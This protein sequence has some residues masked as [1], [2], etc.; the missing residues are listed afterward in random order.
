MA[1]ADPRQNITIAEGMGLTVQIT[2]TLI[3][4]HWL[5][6][7]QLESFAAMNAATAISL[8]F[9]G[10]AFG[11]WV[12]F[13]SALASSNFKDEIGKTKFDLYESAALI[14]SVFFALLFVVCLCA[15]L[16]KLFRIR[17]T[18]A[19]TPPQP[20]VSKPDSQSPEST[21]HES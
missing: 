10:M 1:N 14:L 4:M 11:A 15:S 9:L 12:S 8:A 5:T 6:D 7:D 3:R 20:V 2:P 17:K 18:V 13:Y 19:I 16:R 21:T